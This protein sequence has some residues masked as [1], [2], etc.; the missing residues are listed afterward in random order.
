MANRSDGHRVLV[1]VPVLG[2]HQMT[3]ELLG[4][5]ERES[6]LVDVVVVDNGGDYPP[7]AGEEVLRPGSNL[8]WAGATN[9]ATLERR[10]PNHAGCVWLNNDT[11][12]CAGFVRGLLDCWRQTD[13]GVIGPFYDCYWRHQRLN[14]VVAVDGYRPAT[15]HF[16]APFV[17]GT[18]LFVSAAA[19]DA[20]GLLDADTFSPVG[21]G[22]DIDFCLRA[23]EA[24]VGVGVTRL[25]YLHHEKSVTGRTVFA[26]GLEEY[27]ARGFPVLMDGLRRK[28]GDDWQR[29]AGIDPSTGQTM[30]LGRAA[31][32]RPHAGTA[33]VRARLAYYR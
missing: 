17:D 5:L 7:I 3:H 18:C 4:D 13:L 23:R 28:W 25:A 31:R 29:M 8:G 11:R 12:L 2:H 9:Q 16:G 24:Q 21:W 15:V 1:V 32:I 6:D 26:G 27:A 20:V 33:T 19:I 22:A 10:R 14:R 30:P